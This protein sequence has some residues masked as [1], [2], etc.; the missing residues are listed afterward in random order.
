MN[1]FTQYNPEEAAEFYN[2]SYFRRKDTETK[3]LRKLGLLSGSAVILYIV[4]QNLIVTALEGMDLI[5]LYSKSF[6]F[7]GG[8]DILLILLGILLPFS[9]MGKAMKKYS[10]EDEPVLTEPVKSRSLFIFGMLG[11][12]GCV[13]IANIASAYITTIISLFGYELENPDIKMPDGILGFLITMLKVCILT[14]VVEEYSLRGQILGNLRPYGDTF[15][16][17][18][19]AGIFALMHGTLVQVPFAM[20]AGIALGFFTVRCGSIWPAVIA[21]GINNGL[22]VVITYLIKIVGDEKGM[23]L[24]SYAIYALI[25]IGLI[26]C[27]LFALNSNRIR[28]GKPRTVLSTSEKIINFLFSPTLIIA[29]VIMVAITAT[30]VK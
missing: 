24:Y 30:S 15:A 26:S 18:M 6:I 14:A 23:L 19:A 20:M 3:N 8:V 4:I 25:I 13:M 27:F 11:C 29:F 16:I 22:S 12:T 9:L 5:N 28:P 2:E 10:G 7:Q 1:E 17:V 21:H